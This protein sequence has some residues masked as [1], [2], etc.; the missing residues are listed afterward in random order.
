M[1]PTIQ[2]ASTALDAWT[3]EVVQWHFDPD[4][5]TPFWLERAKT[6][7]FDPRRDIQTYADLDRFG[8]FEDEWLRGGPVRRWVPKAYASKPICTFETGGSTGVPKSRINWMDFR[9]DYEQFSDTLPD[10]FF[11]DTLDVINDPVEGAV[12]QRHHLDA[13]EFAGT[14]ERQQF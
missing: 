2:P 12:G 4:T 1:T 11:H 7:D 14:L 5:G 10:E 9:I 8:S 3:R 13:L 6:L